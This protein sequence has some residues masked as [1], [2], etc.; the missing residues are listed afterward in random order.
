MVKME[1]N[2]YIQPQHFRIDSTVVLQPR[3]KACIIQNN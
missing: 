2:D 3:A 1:K